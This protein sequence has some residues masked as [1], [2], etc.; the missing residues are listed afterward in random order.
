MILAKEYYTAEIP[1]RRLVIKL[2]Q[3][4]GTEEQGTEDTTDLWKQRD[5]PV[6]E[7]TLPKDPRTPRPTQVVLPTRREKTAEGPPQGQNSPTGSSG[8]AEYPRS[9]E[10]IHQLEEEDE[11]QEFVRQYNS[12]DYILSRQKRSALQ[13]AVDLSN[14]AILLRRIAALNNR[15][16]IEETG[17]AIACSQGIT[18]SQRT[19]QVA[20]EQTRV[21]S[22][23]TKVAKRSSRKAGKAI[24]KALERVQQLNE[25]ELAKQRAR[26]E[27]SDADSR[28]NGEES[29]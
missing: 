29:A 28:W 7:L 1:A 14:E 2:P 27:E 9:P 3:R 11:E 8:G 13:K 19:I 10:Y 22:R 21:A 18:G 4:P 25:A 20:R 12:L 23:A 24:E 26:R 15:V 17:K 5:L 6:R 16:A